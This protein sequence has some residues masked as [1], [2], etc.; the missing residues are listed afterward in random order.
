MEP[1]CCI[2]QFSN[3]DLQLCIT[4]FW[5]LF[6]GF[7]LTFEILYFIYI[8]YFTVEIL[9]FF[10]CCPLTS[11]IYGLNFELF[12][13]LNESLTSILLESLFGVLFVILFGVCSSMSS[14]SC[15]PSVGFFSLYK[16]AT[17]PRCDVLV[18]C[19]SWTLLFSLVQVLGCLSALWL[20]RATFFAIEH[21][22]KPFSVPKGRISVST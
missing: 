5:Y 18:T 13:Q 16:I 22:P 6:I 3:C 19:S 21:V 2:F 20:S 8:F 7:I 4:S 9:T 15:S 11:D 17:S 1:L 14:F 12:Y 10:M